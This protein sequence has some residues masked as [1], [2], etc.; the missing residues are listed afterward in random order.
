MTAT[1]LFLGWWGTIS[2]IVTPFLLLN[3][4]GRYLFCLGMS[5]V[6]SGAMPP[7]LT[8]DAVERIKPHV[9]DLF[10]RLNQGE[11]LAAVAPIIADRAGVS[12]GQVA[13]FVQAVVRAHAQQE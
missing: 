9:S 3:N 11:D 5:P 1:T 12:P 2:F 6:P 7:E 10:D 4:I 13:L 8:D